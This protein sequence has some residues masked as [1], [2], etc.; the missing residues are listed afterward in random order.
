ML[1]DTSFDLRTDASGGDPDKYSFTLCRYNKLL[2]SRVLPSGAPFNLEV[3]PRH[4]GYALHHRS[5]LGEFFLTSD[6]IIHSYTRWDKL[7]HITELFP[8]EENEAFRTV[9]STIGSRLVFPGNQIDG[10]QTIN[11]ARGCN[12]KIGDRFDLTLECIRRH[13][14]GQHSPLEDTLKR[15]GDFFALFENFRGYVEFFL[16]QELVVDDY[17][18]VTFLMP[19]DEF[20]TSPVPRDV[21]TYR[22]YRRLSIE[23]V[24]ARNRRIDRYA[25]SY[26]ETMA[27]GQIQPTMRASMSTQATPN[28]VG[29]A[30]VVSA[31]VAPAPRSAR[32]GMTEAQALEIAKKMYGDD[33]MVW[34]T[35]H[36]N[37]GTPYKHP[38]YRIGY[39]AYPGETRFTEVHPDGVRR[40]K[41]V[42]GSW[43]GAVD[44]LRSCTPREA[45]K[46]TEAKPTPTPKAATTNN[47][48]FQAAVA[49][50]AAPAEQK[51][52]A[53]AP[54]QQTR[55]R[56]VGM[57][58]PQE[59]KPAEKLK[60]RTYERLKCTPI[61]VYPDSQDERD[62]IKAA[63]DADNRSVSNYILTLVLR[64]LRGANDPR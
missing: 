46:V 53:P 27:T 24:E 49:V 25:A 1:I 5:E 30:A 12:W 43:A 2:W 20:R 28:P 54:S 34:V 4:G 37:N 14:V 31:A 15:Y 7:R 52:E 59:E 21:D 3:S 9:G 58:E 10:K 39:P 61:M 19:F 55:T 51:A 63:A 26:R 16:L 44:S 23:F 11:G 41:G 64:H 35:T 40:F 22:E 48:E 60:S 57:T 17:S 50:A 47:A 6:T 56:R 42:G 32:T 38:R 29:G 8:E 36:A 33:A 18:Q 45:P 13:Y 62:E